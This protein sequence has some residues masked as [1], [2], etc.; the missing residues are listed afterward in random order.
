MERRRRRC[1]DQGQ[2]FL[3]EIGQRTDGKTCLV[4]IINLFCHGC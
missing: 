3:V 4:E 1:P 2:Y